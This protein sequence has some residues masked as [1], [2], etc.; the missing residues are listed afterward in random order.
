MPMKLIYES[1]CNNNYNHL[2]FIEPLA[3]ERKRSNSASK[4]FK[5]TVEKPRASNQ[6]A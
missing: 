6:A 5:A 2:E 1:F 3:I 4:I